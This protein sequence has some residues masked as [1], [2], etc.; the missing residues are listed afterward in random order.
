MRYFT[1][2]IVAFI[3]FLLLLSSCSTTIFL[4][5]SVPPEIQL[6]VEGQKI[7]IQNFFDYT[8]PEYVR[9]QHSDI[10]NESVKAF[11][12]SLI[13]Y[14]EESD[15]VSA[16][17]GD[18][19]V[20]SDEGRM[21]SDVLDPEYVK[22]TCEHYDADM[23]LAIDSLNIFFD[24][25]TEGD[26]IIFGGEG[27]VKHFFLI[28]IPYL[29]LYDWDG[30]LIDRRTADMSYHYSSRES[31]TA[32]IT[33]KPSL[34]SAYDEIMILAEHAGT[35]Y[36]SNFFSTIGTFPYKFYYG[37][38]FKLAFR[39]M[40]NNNFADAIRELLPLAESGSSKTAKRAAH[41]LY[42]AYTAFGD[43]SN[44]EYWYNKSL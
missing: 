12:G 22:Y 20:V 16:E 18:T 40:M 42:V 7:I 4:D 15:L 13:N 28:Y 43:E 6:G 3:A 35:E 34:R 27:V 39:N 5:R 1:Y 37:E 9:Q 31:I 32:F 26:P 29:S 17:K 44:A 30:T 25:E 19:L 11:S 8:K 24:Y 33:I 21:L 10:Y 14:L 41:N 38:P 36:G 2:R 23:L